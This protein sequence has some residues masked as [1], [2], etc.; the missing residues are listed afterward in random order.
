MV[1]AVVSI[2]IYKNIINIKQGSPDEIKA[3]LI[4][5]IL[6]SLIAVIVYKKYR[7]KEE[8]TYHRYKIFLFTFIPLVVLSAFTVYKKFEFSSAFFIPVC[9]AFMAGLNEELFFRGA[10]FTIAKKEKK[11]CLSNFISALTFSIMHI[12]NIFSG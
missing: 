11:D 1:I 10:I 9:I 2:V 5:L 12:V 4:S 3:I 7:E 6:Q 8:Y